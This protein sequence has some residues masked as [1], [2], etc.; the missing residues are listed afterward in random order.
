MHVGEVLDRWARDAP[1]R[2]ALREP[3]GRTVT[4]RQLRDRVARLAGAFGLEPGDR[5]VLLIPMGIAL[6]EVLLALFWGG[7]VAVLVDPQARD[8][9]RAGLERVGVHG[10]V[11]TPRAHLLRLLIPALRGGRLYASTG[12]C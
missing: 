12:W 11:G 10:L 9:M 3:A 2:V 1:D 7:F 8:R 4:F 5:V 6:Y